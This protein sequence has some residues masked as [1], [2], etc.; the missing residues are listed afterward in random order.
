MRNTL[1]NLGVLVLIFITLTFPNTSILAAEKDEPSLTTLSSMSTPRQD[2]QTETIDGK[3]YAI[4]GRN[5]TPY[6]SSVEV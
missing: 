6:L 4:G 3:I 1:T 5:G 2:F